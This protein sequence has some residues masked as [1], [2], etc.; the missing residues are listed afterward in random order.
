MTVRWSSTKDDL[1]RSSFVGATRLC[2]VYPSVMTTTTRCRRPSAARLPRRSTA[3]LSNKSGL[4]IS[5]S[6]T[7]AYQVPGTSQILFLSN[8]KTPSRQT[9]T[10][11]KTNYHFSHNNKSSPFRWACCLVLFPPLW[12]IPPPF[13]PARVFTE[14]Q[15]SEEAK[16]Q[17]QYRWFPLSRSLVLA[18]SSSS[19]SSVVCVFVHLRRLAST[20]F[21]WRASVFNKKP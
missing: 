14:Q 5:P 11:F 4:A 9:H 10:C 3:A 13:V 8:Q 17:S 12:R 1:A 20:L 2:C 16:Q 6:R 7:R 21:H 19:S 18:S 15:R